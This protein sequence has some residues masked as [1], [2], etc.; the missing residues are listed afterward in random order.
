M[1][2]WKAYDALYQEK[3]LYLL[4]ANGVVPRTV[5]LLRTYWYRLTMVAKARGYF[6]HPFK[7]YRGVTQGKF[8]TLSWTMSSTNG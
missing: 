8:S 6:G 2:L 1:D 5:R 4:A 3:T 7:G